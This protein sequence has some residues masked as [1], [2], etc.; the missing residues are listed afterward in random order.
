VALIT[1]TNDHLVVLTDHDLW[2]SESINVSA[3]E[4]MGNPWISRPSLA[5]KK[6]SPCSKLKDTVNCFDRNMPLVRKNLQTKTITFFVQTYA[7]TLPLFN[8][9]TKFSNATFIPIF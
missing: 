4:N 1:L 2:I 7:C 8:E 5:Y 3:V 6:T 9:R